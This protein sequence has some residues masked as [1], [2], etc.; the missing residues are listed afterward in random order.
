V[1]PATDPASRTAP[2]QP[3]QLYQGHCVFPIP[4][5]TVSNRIQPVIRVE[6]QPSRL[7]LNT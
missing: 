1:R 4:A 3:W 5:G 6:G 2:G 7:T